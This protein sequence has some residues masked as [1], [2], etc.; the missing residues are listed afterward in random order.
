MHCCTLARLDRQQSKVQY[1]SED[2]SKNAK[3]RVKPALHCAKTCSSTSSQRPRG[4][5]VSK[6]PVRQ[7]RHLPKQVWSPQCLAPE[8]TDLSS[9]SASAPECLSHKQQLILGTPAAKL[10]SLCALCVQAA[11]LLGALFYR[12]LVRQ[13][14]MQKPLQLKLSKV[15]CRNAQPSMFST[16]SHIGAC[17]PGEIKYS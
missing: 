16:A 14:H 5:G 7:W 2:A 12:G 11:K 15:R 9:E 3:L 10:H 8:G 6:A 13:L 4:G 1:V 17:R